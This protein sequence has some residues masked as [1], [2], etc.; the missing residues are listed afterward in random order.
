MISGSAGEVR[1]RR[2]LQ[3]R[4]HEGRALHRRRRPAATQVGLTL[5]RMQGC[6]ASPHVLGRTKRT[7]LIWMCLVRRYKI[8]HFPIVVLY[9]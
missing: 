5:F 2:E 7:N 4:V 9:R 6:D 3:R 8:C 1:L